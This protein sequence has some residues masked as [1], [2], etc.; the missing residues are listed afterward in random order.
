MLGGTEKAGEI[1]SA[2]RPS[3][4]EEKNGAAT[5]GQNQQSDKQRKKK[6]LWSKMTRTRLGGCTGL[7]IKPDT[8]MSDGAV[9]AQGR[10][11]VQQLKLC[12]NEKTVREK[13]KCNEKTC[14]KLSVVVA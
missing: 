6:F 11:R 12:N 1:Q 8:K 14:S 7:K 5:V 9:S 2:E 10:K 13:K 4:Q 3:F